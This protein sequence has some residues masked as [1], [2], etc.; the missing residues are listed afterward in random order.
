MNISLYPLLELMS[1]LDVHVSMIIEIDRDENVMMT[2]HSMDN[3]TIE[4]MYSIHRQILIDAK[5]KNH[6]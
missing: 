4:N 6:F 3:N 5:R 2:N 1:L